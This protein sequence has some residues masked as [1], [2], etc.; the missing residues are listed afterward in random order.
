[1]PDPGNSNLSDFPQPNT[2]S[3][4]DIIKSQERVFHDYETSVLFRG[5]K[6]IKK[7]RPYFNYDTDKGH[8]GKQAYLLIL[9]NIPSS[10]PFPSDDNCAGEKMSVVFYNGRQSIVVGLG[11]ERFQSM[12]DGEALEKITSALPERG[13]C[14][15]IATRV[16]PI[17][18]P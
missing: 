9:T 11:P 6:E 8:N 10:P 7:S 2:S 5:I 15:A 16:N 13:T 3:V 17:P 4:M 18:Q 12:A 14:P 1:G